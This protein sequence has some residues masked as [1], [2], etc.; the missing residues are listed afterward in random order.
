MLGPAS[1]PTL[2]VVRSVVARW[3]P[4]DAEELEQLIALGQLEWGTPPKLKK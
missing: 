1:E 3:R 2:N 4:Q